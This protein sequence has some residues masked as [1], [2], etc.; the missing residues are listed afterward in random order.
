MRQLQV[1]PRTNNRITLMIAILLAILTFAAFARVLNCDFTNFDDDRYVT[2]NEQVQRGLTLDGITWALNTTSVYNW[3]PLTWISCMT[4]FSVY[5]LN[6]RGF[7]LTNLLLHMASVLLLFLVLRRMTGSVWRSGFVAALFAVHPLHVESVAWIAERKDVL[8]GLFW[9]LTMW[10]YIRYVERPGVGRYIA[11][12]GFYI[13]GLMSKPMLVTLPIV[14]LLLDYW[15]LGR[16]TSDE[17]KSKKKTP[18]RWIGWRLLREKSPLFVLSAASCAITYVA[19]QTGGAV[20]TWERIPLGLR[21]ANALVSY[22]AYIWKTIL[23]RGLAVYY[24]LPKA[25]WPIWEVVASAA[26]L[27]CLTV[28][29]IRT[30]RKAPYVPVGWLWYLCTLVPVIGIVQVGEQAMADRY[31]YIPLIG[32]FVMISWGFPEIVQRLNVKGRRGDG[33]TGRTGHPH[34]LTVAAVITIAVLSS[35]TWIQTGYW[36]NNEVLYR[37]AIAVTRDSFPAYHN[38]AQYA[39]NQGRPAEAEELLKRALEIAPDSASAHTGLGLVLNAQGEFKEALAELRKAVALEPDTAGFHYNLG[40]TYAAM[41][42]FDEAISK[43]EECLGID[44]NFMQARGAMDSVTRMRDDL[45]LAERLSR[46][47][48]AR[49]PR[50]VTAHYN[51]AVALQR[52]GKLSESAVEYREAIRLDPKYPRAHKNLAVVLFHLEDYDAAWMEVHISR[53][54][55]LSPHPNFI[56]A[57]T[58]K[59]PDPGG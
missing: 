10:A 24:P 55:G 46:Q 21:I 16:F 25:H 1:A 48:I 28:L 17:A 41:G 7:H 27:I 52:Q 5:G 32:I 56:T 19:Q 49:N 4:D 20:Q 6:A 34:T 11:V 51:L 29:A 44:P 31:T 35:L 47:L 3:H 50:L 57:L 30:A 33:A 39:L 14:L 43:Y 26:L 53:K 36:K 13:L 23:P 45:K 18:A 12:L 38:L 2:R 37:H 22:V 9:M 15:P 54:L 42:R 58:K 59:M 8:S 40:N